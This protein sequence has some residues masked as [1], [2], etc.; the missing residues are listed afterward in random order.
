ME[1]ID[2]N[3]TD[4]QEIFKARKYSVAASASRGP[5]SHALLVV[6][7]ITTI[8]GLSVIMCVF[9]VTCIVALNYFFSLTCVFAACYSN[10]WGIDCLQCKQKP[11]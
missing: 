6:F 7:H 2:V 9:H 5:A 4:I 11:G 1:L 3:L 10:Y 8:S